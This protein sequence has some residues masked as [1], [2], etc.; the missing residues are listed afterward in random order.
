M[1]REVPGILTGGEESGG[2]QKSA[3]GNGRASTANVSNRATLSNA[4]HLDF[5][6][7]DRCCRCGCSAAEA[8]EASRPA[9][10]DWIVS[11]SIGLICKP[12]SLHFNVE[13]RWNI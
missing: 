3:S 7:I 10:K 9:L 11:G 1:A 6:K 12:S 8:K 13:M 2:S 4:F 5:L